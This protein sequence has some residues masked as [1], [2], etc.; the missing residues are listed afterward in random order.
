MATRIEFELMGAGWAKC[1]IAV[2]EHQVEV[3]AGDESD[4][5]S[6][7][8]EAVI[9][10]SRGETKA[11]LSFAESSTGG[12]DWSFRR[13]DKNRVRIKIV[14]YMTETAVF[15]AESSV[16]DLA[17][18][19]RINPATVAKAYQ[20]LADAGVLEVRRGDGTYVASSPPSLTRAERTR[21]LTDAAM[22]FASF[23][24]TLGAEREEARSALDAAWKSLE[25][26]AKEKR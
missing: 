12:F 14:E 19:L 21:L 9:A 11:D 4:A 24:A 10:I 2:D 16:R 15:D 8:V 3:I 7:L 17:R 20:R 6:D 13:I 25:R 26:D 1:R 5:L 22:R 18:D 23:G